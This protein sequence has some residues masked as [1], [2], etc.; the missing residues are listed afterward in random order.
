MYFKKFLEANCHRDFKK[1][2]FL[3]IAWHFQSSIFSQHQST[4]DSTITALVWSFKEQ[5]TCIDLT[6]RHF[7]YFIFLCI[8]SP[9]HLL[10]NY[11][12]HHTFSESL[13]TVKRTEHKMNDKKEKK[14][15]LIAANLGEVKCLKEN[16]SSLQIAMFSNW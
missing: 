3:Y 2:A 16:S 6:H 15:Q 12:L 7:S 1:Y 4:V 8:Y 14:K 11:T 9:S 13:E 5:Y 10:R